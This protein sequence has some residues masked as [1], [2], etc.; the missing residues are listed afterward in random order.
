MF[1]ALVARDMPQE[2][3]GLK[4]PT[5]LEVYSSPSKALPKSSVDVFVFQVTLP[6]AEQLIEFIPC[7]G[8]HQRAGGDID[9]EVCF[10]PRCFTSATY[11]VIQV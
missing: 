2:W 9:I 8:C 7:A 3:S 6:L 1:P 10:A 5:D 4:S 11:L